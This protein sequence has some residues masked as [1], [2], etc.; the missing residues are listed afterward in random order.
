MARTPRP[1][2]QPFT[3]PANVFTLLKRNIFPHGPIRRESEILM[4]MTLAPGTFSQ[5]MYATRQ[6]G[7]LESAFDRL[8]GLE[9]DGSRMDAQSMGEF[10]SEVAASVSNHYGELSAALPQS[11][12]QHVQRIAAESGLEA[13]A[14]TVE[15]LSNAYMF[16]AIRDYFG[17]PPKN[18]FHQMDAGGFLAFTWNGSIVASPPESGSRWRTLHYTRMP[19]RTNRIETSSRNAELLRDIVVGHRLRSSTLTTSPIQRLLSVPETQFD[20]FQAVRDSMVAASITLSS[21]ASKRY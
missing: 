9:L 2:H 18:V 6:I 11:D 5:A 13:R 16:R 21:I 8:L 17:L 12:R 15:Y 20:L 1:R 4:T 3:R 19:S 14:A 7:L 10:V